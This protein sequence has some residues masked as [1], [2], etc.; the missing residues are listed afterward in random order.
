MDQLELRFPKYLW[1]IEKIEFWNCSFSI[2]LHECNSRQKLFKII[3][4]LLIL[5]EDSTFFSVLKYEF[6]SSEGIAPIAISLYLG[7]Q[8]KTRAKSSYGTCDE[9]GRAKSQEI[10]WY[11]L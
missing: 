1:K 10:I 6:D 9:A 4:S 7:F 8:E 5:S 3:L 2:L 11:E